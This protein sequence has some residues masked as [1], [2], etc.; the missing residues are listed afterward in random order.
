MWCNLGGKKT[1][2]SQKWG[3]KTQISRKLGGDNLDFFYYQDV[4]AKNLMYYIRIN[5]YTTSSIARLTCIP[6]N[7]LEKIFASKVS[8]PIFF[9]GLIQRITESLNL[10]NDYF[11]QMP[12]DKMNKWISPEPEPVPSARSDLAQ[13]LLNDLDELILICQ[14]YIKN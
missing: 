1:Q 3:K 11:L 9:D 12:I 10:A 2:I 14:F 5:G 13:E 7:D 8:D 4:I 6:K